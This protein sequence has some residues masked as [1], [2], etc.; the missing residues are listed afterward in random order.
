VTGGGRPRPATIYDVARLAE[1]SHQ[2]VAMY[3]RGHAGFRP[4]TRSRVEQALAAL[5]YRPN[6]TARALATR[7]SYRIAAL[8]SELLEVGP[9]KTLQ[10]AADRA[11]EAGYLLDVVAINPR[12]VGSLNRALELVSSDEFAGVL[13]LAPV[14]LLL[15]RLTGTRFA[16]PLI[17][18]TELA[19]VPSIN[20]VGLDLLVDHLADLGHR[21]FFYLGGPSAD[22]LAARNREHA[23]HAALARHGLTSLGQTCGDWS[24]ASGHAAI[25]GAVLDVGVTALVAANDQMALGA[26]LAL[27]RRGL[28]LPR[29]V[30]V[31]GF[32]DIAEAAYFSPPLTTVRIDYASQGRRL[33]DRLLGLVDPGRVPADSG[34]EEPLLLVRSSTGPAPS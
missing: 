24:A 11:R 26:L 4:E 18:E 27:G 7:T 17:A 30:S 5:N 10:G 28:H 15:D 21:G 8:V 32:D 31:T 25:D 20:T 34:A 13:A 6:R 16:A 23:Y 22:W 1:V 19:G 9:G 29:D 12:D 33:V 3:L 14:D 2:T